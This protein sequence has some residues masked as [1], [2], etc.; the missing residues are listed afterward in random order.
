MRISLGSRIQLWFSEKEPSCSFLAALLA[1]FLV[2][3][4]ARLQSK[5]IVEA[6][7]RGQLGNNL[8]IVATAS[9]YA[10]DHQALP[11]F[12]ELELKYPAGRKMLELNRDHVFF[13]CNTSKPPRTSTNKWCE[14][15]FA[16]HEIP[17]LKNVKLHGYFQSEKYFAHH[18]E[19]IL[20]LFAPHPDDM[21][22]IREKYQWILDHPVSVSLHLRQF[23]EDPNGHRY[24][25]YGKDYIKKASQE[26]PSNAHFVVFSNS[27]EFAI[28]NI[29]KEIADR[30][31]IIKDEPHYIC[32]FLMSLC[33]HNIIS[34]STFSWWGGW[35]N[36]NPEKIVIAPKQWLS[37]DWSL[38][39]S[40]VVPETWKRVSA[41]WGALNQPTTY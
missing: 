24:I 32:L 22:Y 33:K 30:V 16:Y 27:I 21:Q 38:D 6:E 28:A 4:P 25:Q 37:P 10:W 26:F 2:F 17:F 19:K 31:T 20:Q 7:M 5:P 14:P 34:N 35:L 40:D 9:A 1:V 13:R 29:P 3:C 8:F 23:H 11:F 15:T 12:P 36:Q 41:K 39:T 18:R